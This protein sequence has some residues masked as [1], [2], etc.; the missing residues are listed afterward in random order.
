MVH[1]KIDKIRENYRRFLLRK[2]AAATDD[3]RPFS[4][5]LKT[6][7]K[8][9]DH[10][11]ALQASLAHANKLGGQ[12][13]EYAN[14]VQ[15]ISGHLYTSPILMEHTDLLRNV[16]AI[17]RQEEEGEYGQGEAI[18]AIRNALFEYAENCMKIVDEDFSYGVDTGYD[19]FI[20]RADAYWTPGHDNSKKTGIVEHDAEIIEL[21]DHLKSDNVYH[22]VARYIL[23]PS[24]GSGIVLHDRKANMPFFFSV[25]PEEF[26]KAICDPIMDTRYPDGEDDSDE[27]DEDAF[28]IEI[29]RDFYTHVKA[30]FLDVKEPKPHIPPKKTSIDYDSDDRPI[31]PE[32]RRK[33]KKGKKPR[34]RTPSPTPSEKAR[35]RKE[36]EDAAKKAKKD[37]DEEA[38]KKKEKEESEG[39]DREYVSGG[40]QFMVMKA[41]SFTTMVRA[42]DNDD[43][44]HDHMTR[45]DTTSQRP[46]TIR[47]RD[48]KP[49]DY[50]IT[51]GKTALDP[52][53]IVTYS[54]DDRKP[55]FNPVIGRR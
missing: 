22:S 48:I 52:L 53:Y 42:Q 20:K 35:K 28:Q 31:T 37:E 44:S 50:R 16:N 55:I 5:V 11:I 24:I 18:T 43:L 30:D 15:S 17:L 32:A 34:S 27:E 1:V 36:D 19:L 23:N 47:M 26:A 45:F 51:D 25:L 38:K 4:E 10:T 3:K 9:P 2:W 12:F 33:K 14:T 13:K 7:G 29:E 54:R 21:K 8:W 46:V 49:G 41:K 40:T 39:K 6:Q